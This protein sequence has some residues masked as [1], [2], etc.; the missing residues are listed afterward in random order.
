MNLT[1]DTSNMSD[2][3]TLRSII[4]AALTRHRL[5]KM[6]GCYQLF[7][8]DQMRVVVED[9]NDRQTAQTTAP[10][11]FQPQIGQI[12]GPA[13]FQPRVPSPYQSDEEDLDPAEHDAGDHRDD[14]EFPRVASSS[15]GFFE[16]GWDKRLSDTR[17]RQLLEQYCPLVV[18]VLNEFPGQLFLAGGS[19]VSLLSSGK[20]AYRADWDLFVC[21]ENAEAAEMVMRQAAKIIEANLDGE[22][23]VTTTTQ[24]TTFERNS[25]AQ[26]PYVKLQI[27][28]RLYPAGRHDMIPGCFDL[29]PSQFIWSPA[30]GLQGTLP[31]MLSLLIKGFPLD[32]H[33]RSPA[34]VNRISKYVEQKG[35]SCFLTGVDPEN[36]QAEF[37]WQ[38]PEHKKIR[39][40]FVNIGDSLYIVQSGG[41]LGADYE[42]A[43][44]EADEEDKEHHSIWT[45]LRCAMTGLPNIT[46]A[47][48]NYEDFCTQQC[49]LHRSLF[50]KFR[51]LGDLRNVNQTTLRKFFMDDKLRKEFCV[52]FFGGEDMFKA[53]RLWEENCKSIAAP[54]VP[55]FCGDTP[56]S[57]YWK[58]ES[59][60][61]QGFG[62]N[63]PRPI[64]PRDYYG[65]S[66]YPMV[67]GVPP[68]EVLAIRYLRCVNRWPL[69]VERLLCRYL[70][71]LHSRDIFHM[72]NL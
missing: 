52:E 10:M 34:M 61:A 30:T 38:H 5:E 6:T 49:D 36:S 70:L 60:G 29:W 56:A 7:T 12:M 68:H 11:P 57:K 50:G 54:L 4:Q 65:E 22:I 20:P 55:K 46:I 2:Y 17:F 27:I 24:A 58:V 43:S 37:G 44:V 40:A 15:T 67:A 39:E 62:Q 23:E 69:D 32:L 13:Q 47:L 53:S 66:Y 19:I 42:F 64:A 9:W 16:T 28:R 48:S 3:T 35:F 1:Q 72:L 71:S 21:A 14:G 25:N 41:G 8:A 18:K 45:N 31:G 63:C 33:R 51:N 26:R 59:P